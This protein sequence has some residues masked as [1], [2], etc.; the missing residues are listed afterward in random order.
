LHGL[1]VIAQVAMFEDNRSATYVV[2]Q[3]HPVQIARVLLA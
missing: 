3:I 1:G 2:R